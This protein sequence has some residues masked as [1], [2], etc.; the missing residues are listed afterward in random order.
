MAS[1]TKQAW[2]KFHL[3]GHENSHRVW[4]PDLEGGPTQA[5]ELGLA[6]G[7]EVKASNGSW[8]K[9]NFHPTSDEGPILITDAPMRRLWI[10]SSVRI[11]SV[12]DVDGRRVRA[13]YYFPRKNSGKYDRSRGFRHEFGEGGPLPEHRWHEAYPRARKVHRKGF[14]LELIDGKFTIE[15]RGIVG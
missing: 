3:R 9:I 13:V 5:A 7:L 1:S 2:A 11:L 4:M 8:R 14:G 10:V 6:Q 15:P 12:D